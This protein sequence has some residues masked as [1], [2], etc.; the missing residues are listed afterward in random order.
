MFSVQCWAF[1]VSQ[2][3]SVFMFRRR[4]FHQFTPPGLTSVDRKSTRLNSSHPSSSYLVPRP[5]STTPFPYTTLF[6]SDPG[7]PDRKMHAANS[8]RHRIKR[9]VRPLP[10][11]VQRSMLGVRCFPIPLSVHVPPPP[12]SP[13]Y[14]AGLN[15]GRSEEHTS[16]LQSPVQLV[17]RPPPRQYYTL[18]L[19]DALPI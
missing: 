8:Q 5:D 2:S 1:D 7:I 19:H 12:V 14:S 10:L 13:I 6:R 9:S 17:P 18:S 15:L 11:D 4:L 3:P 16:E